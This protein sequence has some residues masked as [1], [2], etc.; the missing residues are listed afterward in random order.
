MKKMKLILGAALIAG[1]SAQASAEKLV[2]REVS[3]RTFSGTMN[4]EKNH[5]V[6]II[7][8]LAKPAEIGPGRGAGGYVFLN[9]KIMDYKT[10]AMLGWMRGMCFTVDH[11]DKGPFKGAYTIGA[12]GPFD[13][14]CQITYILKDG[15]IVANGNL[16]LTALEKDQPLSLAVTGGTGKYS[17]ARGDIVFQQDPPGQPITYKIVITYKK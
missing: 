7:D 13:S 5:P 14:A 3:H 2:L 6:M 10:N 4:D 9:N 8:D 17:G 15:Q 1:F 16:D 11:G 12:G